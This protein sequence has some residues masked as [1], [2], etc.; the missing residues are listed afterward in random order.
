M[1]TT[2][3]RQKEYC[4]YN[5]TWLVELYFLVIYNY[6]YIS[7]ILK[8]KVVNRVAL[9]DCYVTLNHTGLLGHFFYPVTK[10]LIRSRTGWTE[11]YAY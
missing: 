1:Q 6:H 5:L 3:G 2:I 4:F 11:H 9:G 8:I 10:P 7:L